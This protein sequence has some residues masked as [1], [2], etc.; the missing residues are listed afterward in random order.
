MQTP[1]ASKIADEKR[2]VRREVR[3]EY[4]REFP[5]ILEHLNAALLV[6]TYQAGKLAV[7]GVH[8]AS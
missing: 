5:A 3:F 4:S 2:P 8:G 6:S 7:V 1:D